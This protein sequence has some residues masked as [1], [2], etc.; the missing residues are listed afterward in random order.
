MLTQSAHLDSMVHRKGKGS[1]Q[2]ARESAAQAALHVRLLRANFYVRFLLRMSSLSAGEIRSFYRVSR[3][4]APRIFVLLWVW[5][6][7][8]K[9]LRSGGGSKRNPARSRSTLVAAGE[10]TLAGESYA[11]PSFHVLST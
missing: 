3:A 10:K 9:R 1:G 5:L 8:A 2:E 6:T 7:P 4:G 11:Y